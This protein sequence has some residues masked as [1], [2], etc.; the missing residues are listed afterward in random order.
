MTVFLLAFLALY[1]AICLYLPFSGLTERSVYKVFLAVTGVFFL[2]GYGCYLLEGHVPD[3]NAKINR[4]HLVERTPDAAS[5]FI[6]SS[7]Q[8]STN[9][10]REPTGLVKKRNEKHPLNWSSAVK[11]KHTI[12]E[13]SIE[14]WPARDSNPEYIG[15]FHNGS[16]KTIAG[17]DFKVIIRKCRETKTLRQKC[18]TVGKVVRRTEIGRFYAPGE[19]GIFHIKI[20]SS[21]LSDN[22]KADIKLVRTADWT[23]PQVGVKRIAIDAAH[24]NDPEYFVEP[25]LAQNVDYVVTCGPCGA[26]DTAT[27]ADTTV[28]GFQ[29]PVRGKIIQGFSSGG[30]DGINIALVKNTPVK[31]AE[32]GEVAYAGSELKGYGNMVLMRHEGGYV[33][34]YAHNSELLVQKGDKVRRGQ[35]IAKSGSS[36]NV[37]SPQLHFELRKG[38][39]P[40][41][42]TRYLD[43]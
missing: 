19:K 18:P 16:E 37:S 36:G 32:N 1:P 28:P 13:A 12:S 10:D 40:I 43:F 26:M 7:E 5:R 4:V 24:Q 15:Y 20:P 17:L 31:A 33:T 38:Q 34:A 22:Y 9:I 25:R 35:V 42:P 3:F 6:P 41:D 39:T 8:P 21:E 2:T 11:E 23:G 14:T 29:W 30:N 27:A